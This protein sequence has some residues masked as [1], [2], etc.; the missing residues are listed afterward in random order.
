MPKTVL[1]KYLKTLT[2]EKIIEFIIDI[3]DNR[4]KQF[5]LPLSAD[6]ALLKISLYNYSGASTNKYGDYCSTSNFQCV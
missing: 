5:E 2:K 6:M 4:I 3:Y 1:N